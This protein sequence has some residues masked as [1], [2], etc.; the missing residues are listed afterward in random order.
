MVNSS[1]M[2]SSVVSNETG[3]PRTRSGGMAFNVAV[4]Q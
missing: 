2:V 1:D 4:P 3:M